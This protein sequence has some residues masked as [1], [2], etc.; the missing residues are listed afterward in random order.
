[1]KHWV[2]RGVV[3]SS[4]AWN[5]F[6]RAGTARGE[7]KREV[8]GR[9]RVESI[10]GDGS[11]KGRRRSSRFMRGNEEEAMTHRFNCSRVETDGTRREVAAR[12]SGGGRRPGRWAKQGGSAEWAGLAAGLAKVSGQIQGFQ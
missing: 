9:R 8:T 3:R 6:Y 4:G 1:V 11:S 12:E 10:N 7:R 5:S 2:A